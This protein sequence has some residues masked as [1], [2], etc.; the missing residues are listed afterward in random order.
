MYTTEIQIRVRYGETD[1]MGYVWYGNYADY[2]GV[3]RIEALRQLGVSYKNLEEDGIM[4]PVFSY[5][6]KFFKPAYFDDELTIKTIIRELP[7][8]RIKFEYETYNKKGDLLNK[9]ETTLVFIDKSTNKP[10]AAPGSFVEKLKGHFD[11]KM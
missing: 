11:G 1:Q 6:V 2:F 4:L 7:L 9:A 8:V 5:S 3:A 10:C